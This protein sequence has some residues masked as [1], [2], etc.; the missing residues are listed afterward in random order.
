MQDRL[1]A[2]KRKAAQAEK[3]HSALQKRMDDWDVFDPDLHTAL[4]ASMTS[5]FSP[6]DQQMQPP[7][8]VTPV[9][10]TAAIGQPVQQ[11]GTS[12]SHGATTFPSVQQAQ[13]LVHQAH[14]GP[15]PANPNGGAV[16]STGGS[17]IS[18]VFPGA[19]GSSNGANEGNG[20]SFPF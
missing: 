8:T 2:T 11:A 14:T 7:E 15:P 1:G 12:Q 17:D 5:P 16:D 6:A 10:S 13:S 19:G 3:R 18:L 4:H 20:P 9:D